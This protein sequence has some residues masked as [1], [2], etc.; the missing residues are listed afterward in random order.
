MKLLK[1]IVRM[2]AFLLLGATA[3]SSVAQD[4]PNQRVTLVVPY[5]PGGT[6]DIVARVLAPILEQQWKQPFIIDN[7]TGAGGIVGTELVVRAKP[8]GYTLLFAGNTVLTQKF[9]MK[10]LSYDPADMRAVVKIAESSY[11]VVTPLSLPVK[12][13]AEF[14]AHVKARPAKSVNYGTIPYTTFD[15]DYH[16]FQQLA[17]LDMTTIPYNGAAPAVQAVLRNDIQMYFSVESVVTSLLKAGR[18]NAIAYTGER[19]SEQFPSVPTLREQGIDFATGFGIGIWAHAKTPDAAVSRISRDIVAAIA[20]PAV[21]TRLKEYGYDVPA[22]P[23]AW[24]ERL[25][26]DIKRY[27]E[28]VERLGFKPQ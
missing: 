12:A 17:G 7:R 6:I 28:V 14:I 2:A 5:P 21:V 11:L 18:L 22:Q 3:L 8:D 26:T 16:I 4:W 10:T 1:K 13:L 27:S 9:F 24:N 15:L 25:Q 19:R 23:L 20:T